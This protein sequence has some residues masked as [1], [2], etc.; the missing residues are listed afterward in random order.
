[1]RFIR[2]LMAA[3][4]FSSKPRRPWYRPHPSTYV[5][6]VAAVIF[7]GFGNIAGYYREP[8]ESIYYRLDSVWVYGWPATYFE[9]SIEFPHSRER[10]DD[11]LTWRLWERATNFFPAAFSLNLAVGGAAP[12]LLGAAFE[13]WR[14]RR[15]HL[16][17]IYLSEL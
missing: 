9:R 4:T 1:M 16:L 6:T 12:L 13:V 7:F 2:L 14:R 5:V 8:G 17:Q 3:P 15:A 10:V 11:S